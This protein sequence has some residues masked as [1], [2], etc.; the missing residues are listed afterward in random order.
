MMKSGTASNG[1]RSHAAFHFLHERWS[2]HSRQLGCKYLGEPVSHGCVRISP[3]IQPRF[4]ALES[5]RVVLTGATPGGES[6]ARG[7]RKS[8]TVP[9]RRSFRAPS[10]NDHRLTP[11]RHRPFHAGEVRAL[12]RARCAAQSFSSYGRAL[13]PGRI[14]AGRGC[15]HAPACARLA[16][17][18][19]LVA[20]AIVASYRVDRLEPACA[21]DRVRLAGDALQWPRAIR[22]RPPSLR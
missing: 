9:F 8:P 2:C 5:T 18:T 6:S 16:S 17:C 10:Y 1:Q 22:R 21:P 20:S 15:R 11:D 19:L 14:V 12:A 4:I 13:P 3:G 7:P